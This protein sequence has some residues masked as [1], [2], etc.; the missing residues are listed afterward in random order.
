MSGELVF[1]VKFSGVIP[2]A[3]QRY[4]RGPALTHTD[5]KKW[6][7]TNDLSHQKYLDKP[8]FQEH[9]TSTLC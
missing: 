9:L 7:Q 8:T 6:T 3:K 5:G 2:P 4:W 1:R